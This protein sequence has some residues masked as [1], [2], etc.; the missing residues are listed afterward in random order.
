MAR[1]TAT[2]IRAIGLRHAQPDHLGAAGEWERRRGAPVYLHTDEADDLVPLWQDFSNSAFL[3]AGRALIA[4]GMP[5]EE[6]QALITRAVQVRSLLVP[7]QQPSLLEHGQR[8]SLAGATYSV[9]WTPGHSD[10]HICLLRD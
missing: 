2:D 1:V 10:G 5:A 3:D 9:H 6:A 8:L 4:H 7:P